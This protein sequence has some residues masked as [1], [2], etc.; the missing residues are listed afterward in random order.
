MTTD[1]DL[2]TQIETTGGET[3][4]QNAPAAG[5]TIDQDAM[6]IDRV[7]VTTDV[8][9]VQTGS[10]TDHGTEIATARDHRKAVLPVRITTALM[11]RPRPT[12]WKMLPLAPLS[13]PAAMTPIP[14]I[15]V[16]P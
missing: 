14:V 4:M 9:L 15:T 5:M 10:Q 7:A 8:A 12:S 16:A 2:G 3:D 11:A 6:L 1:R 13:S